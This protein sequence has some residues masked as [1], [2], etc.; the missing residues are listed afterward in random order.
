MSAEDKPQ[1]IGFE[2]W[3]WV[4]WRYFAYSGLK[5]MMVSWK[6]L[7]H[8]PIGWIFRLNILTNMFGLK[9]AVWIHSNHWARW[10]LSIS[11]LFSLPSTMSLSTLHHSRSVRQWQWIPAALRQA[12]RKSD[13]DGPTRGYNSDAYWPVWE[14]ECHFSLPG[15]ACIHLVLYC[16]SL[17]SS[18]LDIYLPK[19][20]L[21]LYCYSLGSWNKVV[22][23]LSHWYN[24]FNSVMFQHIP[25]DGGSSKEVTLCKRSMWHYFIPFY[26]VFTTRNQ[27]STGPADH[28]DAPSL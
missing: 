4:I 22:C 13:L 21:V 19:A 24:Q 10:N 28:P 2:R 27:E 6:K 18:V 7:I 9:N 8:Q 20:R 16:C 23:V 11:L 14:T 3:I 26:S 1:N 25:T 5:S 15:E 17:K 12:H